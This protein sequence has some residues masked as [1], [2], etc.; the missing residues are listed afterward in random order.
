MN[1]IAVVDNNI[2]DR[3]L[4]LKEEVVKRL[5]EKIIFQTHYNIFDETSACS[6]E[7]KR[8]KLLQIYPKFEIKIINDNSLP[9]RLPAT[10]YSDEAWGMQKLF[11]IKKSP[12]TAKSLKNMR[13]DSL[14]ILMQL[15]NQL[16]NR[17]SIL[18]SDNKKDFQN[19]CR[20]NAINW[21]DWSSFE[22]KI[23]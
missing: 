13:N 3:L 21:C 23:E 16:S 6:N 15:G 8:Q 18:I 4:I 19:F 11:M 20:N 14:L 17:E 2:I 1:T 22:K 7:E 10:L 9:M 5:N 12:T